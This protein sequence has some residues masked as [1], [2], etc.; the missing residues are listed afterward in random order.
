MRISFMAWLFDK[1]RVE[2]S[3]SIVKSLNNFFKDKYDCSLNDPKS[4]SNANVINVHS[5]GFLDVTKYKKHYSKLVY[6]LHGVPKMN[7]FQ[8]ID[9]HMI[10]FKLGTPKKNRAKVFFQSLVPYSIKVSSFFLPLFIKRIWLRKPRVVVVPSK[11]LFDMLNIPNARIIPY[12]VNVDKFRILPRTKSVKLK[13]AYFGHASVAKG[14]L[15]AVDILAKLDSD[16]FEKHVFVTHKHKW[17]VDYASKSD[18]SIV[19][20]DFVSDL[21]SALNDVDIIVLPFRSPTS[22][23][24]I[25]IILLESMATQRAIVTSDMPHIREVCEDSVL[26]ANRFDVD[27]FVEKINLLASDNS[28]M[29]SLGVK[30]RARVVKYYNEVDFFKNYDDLFQE[31][32]SS[33]N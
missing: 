32:S 1:V 22:A 14:T 18:K 17:L 2:G 8:R 23:I 19:I 5:N 16:K 13:V 31:F 4:L 25:P 10:G 33:A 29:I 3:I 11:F 12:G 24:A 20:H 6:S 30:A 9:E 28:K 15:E 21:V 26:Y 7:P 27:G